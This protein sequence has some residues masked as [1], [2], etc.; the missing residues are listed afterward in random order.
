MII[1]KAEEVDVGE[2]LFDWRGKVILVYL[3][4]DEVEI[5]WIYMG[6][7]LGQGQ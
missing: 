5:F 3:L 6:I 4:E 7:W 2:V 1:V